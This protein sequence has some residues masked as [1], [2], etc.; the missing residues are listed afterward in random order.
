VNSAER[1]ALIRYT[2]VPWT[3]SNNVLASLLELDPHG[4]HTLTDDFGVHRG[5][6]VFIHRPNTTNGA[7]SQR[8][9][10][11]GE[12]EAWVREMPIFHPNDGEFSGWRT[13]MS[14][15]GLR[16]SAE[17]PREWPQVGLMRRQDPGDTTVNW[18]GEVSHVSNSQSP[19][20]CIHLDFIVVA[21]GWSG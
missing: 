21:D 8:V 12:L 7:P 5:D 9:P 14:E 15:I 3:S 4:T 13:E 10:R 20:N 6:F 2:D 18:F 1:T 17:N 16:I 11:I 19:P